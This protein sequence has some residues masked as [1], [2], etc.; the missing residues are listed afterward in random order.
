MSWVKD[1]L[2]TKVPSGEF[3]GL[4][5]II[6]SL[7]VN[8][9]GGDVDVTRDRLKTTKKGRFSDILLTDNHQLDTIPLDLFLKEGPKI[10]HQVLHVVCPH[11]RDRK[12]LPWIGIPFELLKGRKIN[13]RNGRERKTIAADI[14]DLQVDELCD[15][16]TNFLEA[17]VGE[18]ELDQ[19]QLLKLF[20]R[21][22]A[23][24]IVGKIENL[25]EYG[26]I[27]TSRKA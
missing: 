18:I 10:G 21:R 1:L 14:K 20:P 8:T 12:S 26:G 17:V 5:Q 11:K 25:Q 4:R 6:E 9:V 22:I 23:Q 16:S 7:H 13:E 3:D 24:C 2:T 27:E 19:R 15:R